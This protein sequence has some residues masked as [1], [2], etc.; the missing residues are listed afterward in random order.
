MN[1]GKERGSVAHTINIDGLSI[2][3]ILIGSTFIA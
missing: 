1:V 2:D 3:L